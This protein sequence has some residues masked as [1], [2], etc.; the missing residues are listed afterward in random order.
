MQLASSISSDVSMRPQHPLPLREDEEPEEWAYA[1]DHLSTT[2]PDDKSE[3]CPH[4]MEVWHYMGSI[5]R[6][7]PNG[8][9][10]LHQFRHGHHPHTRNRRYE[11]IPASPA[12]QRRHGCR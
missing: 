9:T 10:I 7:T 8:A 6:P 3:A 1:W 11:L 12:F 2:T 4:C 5:L